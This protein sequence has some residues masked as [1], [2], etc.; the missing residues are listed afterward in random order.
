MNET[1]KDKDVK[2][3]QNGSDRLLRKPEDGNIIPG[4]IAANGNPT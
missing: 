2:T 4:H 3:E 1:S